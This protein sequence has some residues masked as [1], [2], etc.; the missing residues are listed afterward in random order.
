MTS[1]TLRER[2]YRFVSH[3]YV[4]VV[5][6]VLILV[7]GGALALQT[8]DLRMMQQ[9]LLEGDP[10]LLG[11]AV[12]VYS[13]SWPIRG[14]R[15]NVVLRAMSYQCGVRF[16]TGAV[17]LSQAVNLVIPARTGDAIRA[18]LV[19]NRRGVPYPTGAAS[20]AVER[21]FDL[22]ALTT[23]GGLAFAWL[24]YSDW[25]VTSSNSDWTIIPNSELS[26]A[27]TA[28]VG[29]A[30]LAIVAV[31][32]AVARTDRTVAPELRARAEGSR[33]SWIVDSMIQVG[34][35]VRIVAADPRT[36][37]RIHAWSLAVWGLDVLT[38][39]FV[40]AALVG[41][42]SDISSGGLVA[43][44]AL[45]VSVGNLAKVLPLSQGGIGLYEAAFTGLI[46]GITPIAAGTALAVA[47]LDHALK[48][49]VTFI[50][51]GVAALGFNVSFTTAP[52][53]VRS[54]ETESTNF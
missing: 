11:I 24:L 50:G 29:M 7:G 19:K 31:T 47:I 26:F 53:E 22:V 34:A 3:R 30:V 18:Y 27:V 51:G 54:R 38:A 13:L 21:V 48:N 49:A 15:Y 43:V 25:T 32:V 1:R 46:V 6:T 37:V 20:L 28:A 36:V 44:G 14:N 40:L 33:L 45:A 52:E 39:V 23:F 10:L 17:F 4:S 12:I 16:L 5:G 9:T 35:S 41:G 2:I 42:G 8:V